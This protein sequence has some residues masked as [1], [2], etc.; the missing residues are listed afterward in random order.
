MIS[1]GATPP[2]IA[3]S[4]RCFDFASADDE[5]IGRGADKRKRKTCNERQGPSTGWLEHLDIVRWHDGGRFHEI[6][7]ITV[8]CFQHDRVAGANPLQRPEKGVAMTRQHDVPRFAGQRCVG[9]VADRTLQTG[10]RIT[11]NHD[12]RESEARDQD[13][14]DRATIDHC[15]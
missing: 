13:L 3:A 14:A 5:S 9:E 4:S 11:L 1:I 12:G 7:E 8:R 2:S 6:P 10:R 15:W